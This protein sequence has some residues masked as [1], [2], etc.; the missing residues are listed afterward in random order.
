MTVATA[1]QIQ[2]L[3][4]AGVPAETSGD[5]GC[6][7]PGEADGEAALAGGIGIGGTGGA[8]AITG[9]LAILSPLTI[10]LL[11]AALQALAE[12]QSG[13][14][15]ASTFRGTGRSVDCFTGAGSVA[16]EAFVAAM[17]AE[18]SPSPGCHKGC[19]GCCRCS[20]REIVWHRLD[21]HCSI[22]GDIASSQCV[23]PSAYSIASDGSTFS[24]RN[25]TMTFALLTARSISRRTCGDSFACPEK[26][27]T[28]MFALDSASMM[29]LPHSSPA[30]TSRGAIQ[31]E[32]RRASSAAHA[33]SAIGLSRA[34][35]QRKT[36]C[37]IDPARPNPH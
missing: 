29:D 2:A 20:S 28:T 26:I 13:T 8:A 19:K 6:T 1:P 12:C 36:S 5:L 27:R 7:G 4:P 17:S 18:A 37:A 15:E 3:L 14:S 22:G 35:W 9:W 23:F 25:G 11:G 32:I 10:S 34:E 24:I 21:K 30:R 33:A 31:Q 16:R